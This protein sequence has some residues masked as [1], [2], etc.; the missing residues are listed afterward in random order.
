MGELMKTGLRR[1]IFTRLLATLVLI[2]GAFTIVR[3]QQ[4]FIP[5]C[6]G[7]NDTAVLTSIINGFGGN[8]GTLTL[9]Y[10][11]DLTKR[12][13][14]GNLVIPA[15]VTLDNTNGSGIAVING[16]TL[17]IQGPVVNPSGK[18]LTFGT[19]T[20]TLS[21]TT[22]ESTAN[23][24]TDT[25]LGNSNVL[26][27]S[28][29]AVKTYVDN[30]ISG[31]T[32][33]SSV[34]GRTGAVVAQSG[35]YTWAQ[36]N[37]TISSLAD[38]ATKNASDLTLDATHRL[39][40]DT[41]KST[42]N[43]KQDAL[44]F[45]PENVA[46]KRTS[47]QVT[48]DDTHYPSEK[49]VKD[50]LD[51]KLATNGSAANLT[52]FPTLNQNTT[53]TAANLSGTP[54]LPN[55]T[56]ATTQ[57]QADG[58]TKL[59]TTAYV[60]T[61][62]AGKQASGAY[63]TAISV[64]SA[65]GVSG[66][67]SGGATPTLTLT[68]Q[69]GAADGATKGVAGFN[70]SDFDAASGI[71][72]L[73][74]TNAQKATGSVPGFLTAADWTTFNSKQPAGS[75]LT[76]NQTVTLS[77]DVTG[78][79]AT[80]ITTTV[81]NIPSTT[82]MAGSLLATNVTA[83]GTP[84]SG[85]TSIY[86]D[87]T[88]K[89]LHDKNDAGTIG[90]T[91]V[92]DTGASNNFLTAISAAGAI[93]KSQPSCAS[94]SNSGTGCSA[95][96]GITQL[97]GDVTAGAGSGSQAA[98]VVNLPTGVTQAG[99]LAATAIVAPATPA[100]GIGRIYV[101]STSKNLAVK[102]DAGVVK[103]G[104][105]TDTGTANNYISAIS[106]AGAITKSRPTCGTLFD[107]G[108]GCTAATMTATVGG[109][110]PTPPN[111]TTTF[112]RG[113]GSFATPAG[114]GN[115]STTGSPASG[116]LAKFSGTTT[117]TNG[118]LS[119]DCATSGTL[120]ITCTKTNG[121]SFVASATTDTTSATNIS[122]GT[123]ADGRLSAN[124]PL[125]SATNAFTGSNSFSK[126]LTFSGDISP[127]ALSGDV[128][129]YNPTG[130]STAFT[131]RIDGGA[132]DRNITGLAG[133]AAGRVIRIINVGTTNNLTLVN[134]S[135]SSTTA[136]DRFLLPN[137]TILPI[138][139][140]IALEYDGTTN[141]WRPWSRALANTGVTAGSYGSATQVGTFTVDAAGR[142]T[143]ASNA[144]VTPAVG[145]I[146]G[147][148]TGV[149]TAL[150]VNVGSAGAFVVNGGALGTPSSGTLTN[151]T[152]LP[153]A[154]LS[155]ANNT[156]NDVSITKH[157]FTP[158]A[159][160][161]SSKYLRGDATWA[162]VAA[163]G[164]GGG[165]VGYSAASLSLSGT[166][167][168]PYV[169]GGLPSSTEANVDS[170]AP[171]A[172]TVSNFYVDVSAA[173]GG[174]NSLALTIRKNGA[175][176]S[177]T[178]T[179]SGASATSC[180]DTAHS[181]A[182]AANDQLTVKLVTTGIIAGTPTLVTTM[183]YGTT[184][185]NG[186]V[187]TGTINQLGYYAAGGT[188]ISG[189]PTANNAVVVTSNTGVPS[190]AAPSAN[191]QVS[192]S[193]LD[194]IQGIQTASSPQFAALGLGVAAPSLGIKSTEGVAPSGVTSNDFL[195]PDS[196]AHRWKMNNNNGGAVNVVA[197]GV[198]INT[199]DQVTATHLSSA[200]PVAQG[201]TGLSSTTINQLLYSSSASTIAG[202]ATANSSVLVTN[203]SGVPSLS[204]ALP[205]GVTAT[206]QSALD[207]STKA[208]TTAYVNAT[209]SFTAPTL[210]NS[211]VDFGGAVEVSGYA[212]IA[213]NVVVLKGTI[214]SG[215][216]GVSAFLL[217]VGYRPTGNQLFAVVS[218]SVFGYVTV[219]SDG[220]VV[221]SSVNNTFV[222]L[223]GIRFVATQ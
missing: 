148:G 46:N 140:A 52:S 200:L 215:T 67:S 194:T 84:V 98:T 17:T 78:S 114:G 41:E 40:T 217:P 181:F 37:K 208:A 1:K 31:T 164:S 139:T 70:A 63:V 32:P 9:P 193:V 190:V 22:Y 85:K 18:T 142:L 199:S 30:A 12:C 79:G 144:T 178:C 191:L 64:A 121:S 197:S 101:D 24:T 53:G 27:P 38:L 131:I 126:D 73:D 91:V 61:G 71:V 223:D 47:F 6:Q 42:W 136:G 147:L 102:D 168:F 69:N 88:D 180:N 213:N 75:Y 29:K 143:A 15:N 124:V 96:A 134:Q 106:D 184:N 202:L 185:S 97:T 113:D 192:S 51:A 207:N 107:S 196:T 86:V 68:V 214:K 33:V 152:G 23:K 35:D 111:N 204:T 182:V 122:S 154:G 158:V 65:N 62:L 39:V 171:V 177:V 2:C 45:T 54:T 87:S 155:L 10:K 174:G 28:Q 156:T 25:S 66:S 74:Y 58:S 83:P 125:L 167:Y 81:A 137:D 172:A 149:A 55:G 130:L 93:S 220:N 90:T 4:T 60:D 160:N 34:F 173:P 76:G 211:W 198:D 129:D 169:G 145:S 175:D 146:T 13:T 16:A 95:A 118:D 43:G 105:Q 82:P 103:H 56:T 218:N 36:V 44:G 176:T 170:P 120:S 133:G 153:E 206:T 161:D 7:T 205:N 80:S 162:S 219:Q 48:P 159:P 109:L 203:G 165:I 201:G 115:V 99:Y 188:A 94:L 92:A 187:N 21:G 89:R 14:V 26:Y 3:S 110:V 150:G 119:G 132:A 57:S 195:Y 135:S 179:I 138:N 100:A 8:P 186:T 108:A 183:Q 116:N 222:S 123:L 216:T 141:R 11:P 166:L 221:M 72:S 50:S 128:N 210:L 209:P 104:V 157:G 20:A 112:L 77:G 127:T 5:N 49:L 212:K 117:V 163:T 19:G 151:V 189:L 59:A